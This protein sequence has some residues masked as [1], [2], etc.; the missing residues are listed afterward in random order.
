MKHLLSLGLLTLSLLAISSKTNAQNKEEEAI[1]KTLNQETTSFFKANYAD[2]ANTWAHDSAD[3]ILR[4]GTNNFQELQGWNAI[5]KEYAQNIKNMTPMNDAAMATY[6]NKYDYHF[7]IKGNLATV[8]FKE[9][10]KNPNTETRTLVKQNGAWKILNYVLING[11]S[12]TMQNVINNMKAFAGKWVLDGKAT[13]E[14]SNGGELNSLKFELKETP[15][16]LEQ[17]SKA[18]FTNN[19][20]TYAPPVEYEY[21][22]PDY[23]TN[24]VSYMDISKNS[25]GQTFPQMG[26]VTS[27]QPNSFTVTVMYPHKPTAVQS[28]YTVTMQNGKWYQVG[29]QYDRDGKQTRTSTVDLR[30]VE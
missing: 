6:L 24:T 13:M 25:S 3:Y 15:N 2:W 4:T 11:G 17:L 22:I 19:N 20:V 12:Y 26:T 21:F 16:G 18:I 7:Y 27:D 29:K 5:S 10:N 14:P 23:N 1:K 30:R 9:G 28:E 8:S